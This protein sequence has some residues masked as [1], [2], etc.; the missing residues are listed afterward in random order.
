[1]VHVYAECCYAAKTW[2]VKRCVIIKAEV[3]RLEGCELCDNPCYVVTNLS[4]GSK[5]LYENIYC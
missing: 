1:M 3:V 2:G 5:H 4:A